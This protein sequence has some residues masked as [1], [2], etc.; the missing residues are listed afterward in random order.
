MLSGLR[1][2][3]LLKEMLGVS[4]EDSLAHEYFGVDAHILWDV[5]NHHVPRLRDQ[6][7]KVDLP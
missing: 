5:M 1:R 6:L 7:E 4:R 3:R 2:D